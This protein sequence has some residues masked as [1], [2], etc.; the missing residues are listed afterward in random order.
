VARAIATGRA[1][2]GFGIEAGARALGLDFVPLAEEQYFLACLKSSLA[3]PATRALLELLRSAAWQDR[4]SALPGYTP[5]RSGEV[6]AMNR[7]L[8]WWRFRPRAAGHAPGA[9]TG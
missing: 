2:A 8:P 4:L 1:D 7:E 3:Q 6:L 5:M 9:E